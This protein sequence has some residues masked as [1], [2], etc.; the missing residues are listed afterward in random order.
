MEILVNLLVKKIGN[1]VILNVIKN[2]FLKM[3]IQDK[4]I[5]IIVI[6]IAI[7]VSA[8]LV[9]ATS[10]YSGDTIEIPF[11]YK[12]V[13]CSI[14]GN[15]YNLEGLN[16]SW[17]GESVFLSTVPNYKPDNFTIKCLV[18]KYKESGGQGEVHKTYYFGNRKGKEV[19]LQN[20]T[21]PELFLNENK[22]V[23]NEESS[24]NNIEEANSKYIN[25]SEI[26]LL[27][28]LII[29]IAI[30]LAMNYLK[31]SF[32]Q[33]KESKKGGVKNGQNKSNKIP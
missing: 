6:Y 9:S 16:L 11:G 24:T 3:E 7:I 28:W 19:I 5:M 23:I 10:F 4:D 13:N 29:I 27:E 33:L 30:L 17:E 25:L 8:G 18:I 26:K 20:Q 12:I 22:D 21:S 31:K 1:F 32:I 14:I 2:I 15:T